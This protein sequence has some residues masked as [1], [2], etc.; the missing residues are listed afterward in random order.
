[1]YRIG[2]SDVSGG[3]WL[4]VFPPQELKPLKTRLAIY[5]YDLPTT[6]ARAQHVDNEAGA[7]DI[8]TG[9]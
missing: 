4:Q 2:F 7:Q 1:V 9:A 3:L 6:L 8:I 5:V